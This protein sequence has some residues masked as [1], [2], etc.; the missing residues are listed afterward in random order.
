[1]PHNIRPADTAYA[2]HGAI[3][4][5]NPL[6][7]GPTIAAPVQV[8]DENAMMRGNP[9]GGAIIGGMVRSDG[10]ANARAT[11]KKNAIA[12]MKVVDVGFVRAYSMN[13]SAEIT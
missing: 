1:M 11:P 2:T 4:Y 5:T 8:A 3:A 6:A 13:A 9:F 10:D 12:N 7:A